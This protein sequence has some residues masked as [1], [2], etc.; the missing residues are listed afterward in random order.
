MWRF[1]STVSLANTP[2]PSGTIEMPFDTS[3]SARVREISS[4]SKD[5]VPARG[6]IKPDMVR[7]VVVLPAPFEPISAMIS[8]VSTS[9]D[10]PLS[11]WI[12]P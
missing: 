2:R 11:A 7:S 8:P 4:P 3:K 6:S 9:N 1:S 10:T 12:L 5:T